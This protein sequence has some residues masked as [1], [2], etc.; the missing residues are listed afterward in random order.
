MRVRVPSSTVGTGRGQDDSVVVA[1]V[2]ER[3]Q[4]AHGIDTPGDMFVGRCSFKSRSERR[5]WTDRQ[6][7]EGAGR[8]RSYLRMVISDTCERAGCELQ[9]V[10]V[11]DPG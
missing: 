11:C 3:E 7:S 6:T 4:R 1:L 8:A 2:E 5:V 9:A 10:R